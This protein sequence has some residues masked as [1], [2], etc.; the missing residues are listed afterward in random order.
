M[1]IE[2]MYY[3]QKCNKRFVDYVRY[4]EFA[5]LTNNIKRKSNYNKENL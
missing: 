1:N 4:I 5:K 2:N 3:Q